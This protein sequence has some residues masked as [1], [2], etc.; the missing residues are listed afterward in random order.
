PCIA[1]PIG[2]S[3]L[4]FMNK[5]TSLGFYHCSQPDAVTFF[6]DTSCVIWSLQCL[7][8]CPW[9]TEELLLLVRICEIQPQ[10]PIR[11][12]HASELTGHLH[13]G[14]DVGVGG[15]FKDELC[16]DAIIPEPEIGWRGNAAVHA[17][18]S[19]R[20]MSGVSVDEAETHGFLLVLY[21]VVHGRPPCSWP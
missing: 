14:V 21:W 7:R 9:D 1:L 11:A 18:V 17:V 20:D 5:Q 6:L 16:R 4:A 10:R 2:L 12:K 15:G 13:E 3:Y 19:E 8:N